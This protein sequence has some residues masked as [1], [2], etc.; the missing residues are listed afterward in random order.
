MVTEQVKVPE[1][2]PINET[3]LPHRKAVTIPETV[4]TAKKQTLQKVQIIL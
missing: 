2:T 4:H 3:E 1:E